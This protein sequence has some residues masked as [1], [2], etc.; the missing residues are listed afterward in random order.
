MADIFDGSH[1]TIAVKIA[2][3]LRDDILSKRITPG[4]HI[5]A[6]EI[7]DYWH[8]SQV[9]V[10]E[11]FSIL[12][13]EGFLEI[14]AY[15]GATVLMLNQEKIRDINEIVNAMEVLLCKKCSKL[16]F[17]DELIAGLTSINQEI[18]ALAEKMPDIVILSPE[19]LND[20]VIK[21]A[22]ERVRLNIRFHLTMFSIVKDSEPYKLFERYVSVLEALRHYYVMPKSRVIETVHEHYMMI[23]AIKAG[24]TERLEQLDKL[25]GEKSNLL[26]R[27]I[28]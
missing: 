7:A 4:T 23:D 3:K 28:L 11:A 5:T 8:S 26:F 2:E 16:S 12:A 14:N 22:T 10:R 25:H 13:G 19:D 9:P 20:E 17:P 1:K 18:E 15:R 21:Y 24:E 27:N 6:K